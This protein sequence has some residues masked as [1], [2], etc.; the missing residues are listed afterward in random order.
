MDEESRVDSCKV[1]VGQGRLIVSIGTRLVSPPI[2]IASRPTDDQGNVLHSVRLG[3]TSNY[4]SPNGRIHHHDKPRSLYRIYSILILLF[5]TSTLP[6]QPIP[7]HISP[8]QQGRNYRNM[9]L[10]PRENPGIGYT[11]HVGNVCFL[12][13]PN[14][15]TYSSSNDSVHCRT[16]T[17]RSSPRLVVQ[18]VDCKGSAEG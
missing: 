12:R 14:E 16:D 1:Q 11:A 5:P 18:A 9:L 2:G 15:G 8:N 17:C 6:E 7:T 10:R 13:R 3:S 4:H